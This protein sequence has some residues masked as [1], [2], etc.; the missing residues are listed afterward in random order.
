LIGDF[1]FPCTGESVSY[2][3]AVGY[4]R[5]TI[6]LLA[7]G[8]LIDLA[9]RGGKIRLVCSPDLSGEDISAIQRGYEQR[10]EILSSS[11]IFEM[12]S[13]LEDAA[14]REKAVILAT[15]IATGSMDLKIAIRPN[16]YGLF[17]EKLGIFMDS[18]E[19]R[20]SFRGS[21]NETW[22]GWHWTGNH[23]AF[24]VFRSWAGNGEASRV[25][26]HAQYFDELWC[27]RIKNVECLSLPRL[28][29]EYIRGAARASLKSL[30]SEMST[31]AVAGPPSN[32]AS[33]GC[34]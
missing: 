20:V 31:L 3:R 26:G 28:A 13:V 33:T 9:L 7:G 1:Y 22:S 5:S 32:E 25:A 10:E 18:S 6:L 14:T 12:A 8:A 27:G 16:G 30:M 23:E 21:S 4:F 29:R 11:L 2:D 19:D 17:H 34:D 24:E 15:L